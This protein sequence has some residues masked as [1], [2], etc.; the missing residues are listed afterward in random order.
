[1]HRVLKTGF[2]CLMLLGAADASTQVSPPSRTVWDEVYFHAQADRGEVTFAMVCVACHRGTTNGPILNSEE[3]YNRWRDERLLSL[4]TYIKATMPPDRPASLTDDEYLDL[5]VYILQLNQFP[6]GDT[7]ILRPQLG[8]VVFSGI[9]GY[10]PLPAGTSVYSIGCLSQTESGSTLTSATA[11]SRSRNLPEKEQAFKTL[12]SLPLGSSS[13]RLHG[14]FDSVSNQGARVYAKGFLT[15]PDG[16][17]IDVA[18]I[19]LLSP[20]CKR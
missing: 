18:A 16:S 15:D 8:R 19:R 1:L 3:F 7:D 4:F 20:Q 5:L 11:P 10:S 13:I 12:E 14:S 17:G 9:D 6:A 2:L